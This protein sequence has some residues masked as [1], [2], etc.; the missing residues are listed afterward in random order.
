MI[1]EVRT[2]VASRVEGQGYDWRSY[3]EGFQ[4]AGHILIL[5]PGGGY[6]RFML[7][8]FVTLYTGL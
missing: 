4:M 3:L 7:L 8:L 2:K 1:T 5:D 6:S